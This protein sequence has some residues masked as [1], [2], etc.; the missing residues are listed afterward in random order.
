MNLRSAALLPL[1]LL[2]LFLCT[3]DRAASDPKVMP[4]PPPAVVAPPA[5]QDSVSYPSIELERLAHLFRNATYM[6]ATFYDLPISINQSQQA[7]IQTT[8]AGISSEP[9]ALYPACKP[10]GHMWFQIDGVNIE[11]ADIYFADDCYGYVW[12][13]AGKPAYSNKFT[14]EGAQFYLNLFSQVE[15]RQ[16]Q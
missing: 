13:E 2:A 3:C 16:P 7:Q 12:Y 10:I 8:I 6:D 4:P 14:R 1:L 9:F 5:D 11:E 15:Q